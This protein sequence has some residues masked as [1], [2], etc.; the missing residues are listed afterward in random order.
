MS[1]LQFENVFCKR[2]T[3]KKSLIVSH[4]VSHAQICVTQLLDQT[5]ISHELTIVQYL[6]IAQYLVII[7]QYLIF[8]LV[9]K[10]VS[11]KLYF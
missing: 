9:Q 10:F 3:V 8:F 2:L 4:F 6:I 5:H 7:A 1:E 11:R